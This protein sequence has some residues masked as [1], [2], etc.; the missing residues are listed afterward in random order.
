MIDLQVIHDG[1]ISEYSIHQS[2]QQK[3]IKITC[4]NRMPHLVSRKSINL[5]HNC[6]HIALP[7]PSDGVCNHFWLIN[8]TQG[9]VG[10]RQQDKLDS[11][12]SLESSGK[13]N[14]ISKPTEKGEFESEATV[15]VPIAPVCKQCLVRSQWDQELGL[16][17]VLNKAHTPRLPVKTVCKS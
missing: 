6:V 10:V 17:C 9:I 11:Q 1:D 7:G 4:C 2:M 3:T 8:D 16:P 14:S 12:T 15:S 5:V 13:E